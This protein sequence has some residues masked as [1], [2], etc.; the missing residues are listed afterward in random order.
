MTSDI[1]MLKYI[2]PFYPQGSEGSI[3]F[4]HAQIPCLRVPYANV[5]RIFPIPRPI[6]EKVCSVF[7]SW[8]WGLNHGCI[9]VFKPPSPC[10]LSILVEY[11]E[12]DRELHG[13]GFYF[14]FN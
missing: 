5:R 12:L 3:E 9:I 2:M 8:D 11:R 6:A 10:V 14:L 7:G 13:G 1:L 4:M